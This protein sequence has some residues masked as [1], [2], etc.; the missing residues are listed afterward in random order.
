M[1]LLSAIVVGGLVGLALGGSFRN[2]VRLR[3]RW[4]ALMFAALAIQ[5]VI[6]SG[7]SHNL[8]D[9]AVTG[10]YLTSNGIA[11]FWLLRNLR[12]QGVPCITV[13]WLS[14]MA[15]ILANGGRMP[16][17]ATLLAQTR[18]AALVQAIASGR[19]PTNGQLAGPHTRL[20]WLTDRLALPHPFP[21]PNVYSVGDVLIWA[22]VVW[23]LTAAMRAPAAPL[24]SEA[25][26]PENPRPVAA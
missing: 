5:L 19:L 11:A 16:V 8:G 22:G 3:L 14:N 25:S 18:G 23:L 26:R 1:S 7:L 24:P 4:N 2:L 21:F 20:V 12:L 13:G 6:F 15:A 10:L 9:A 17:D